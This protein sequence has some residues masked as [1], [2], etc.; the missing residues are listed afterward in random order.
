MNVIFFQDLGSFGVRLPSFGTGMSHCRTFNH[1]LILV[2][3]IFSATPSYDPTT[4]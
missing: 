1:R 3:H 2:L 4:S